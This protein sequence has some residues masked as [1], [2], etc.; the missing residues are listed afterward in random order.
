VVHAHGGEIDLRDAPDGGLQV[1]VS[2]PKAAASR[3]GGNTSS[4]GG[5]TSNTS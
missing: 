4:S 3:S 5:K 1:A 2:L